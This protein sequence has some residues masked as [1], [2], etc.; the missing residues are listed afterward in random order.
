MK[1]LIPRQKMI[2]RNP[3]LIILSICW[4][5]K[6]NAQ[7][8]IHVLGNSIEIMNNDSTPAINDLTDF[9]Q[10]PL[11]SSPKKHTFIINNLGQS[12]A[13]IFDIRFEGPN[14][15]NFQTLNNWDTSIAPENDMLLEVGFTPIEGG[16]ANTKM[17]IE[18]DDPVNGIFII[19]LTGLG[20]TENGPE[21]MVLGLDNKKIMNQQSTAD[22]LNGTDFGSIPIGSDKKTMSF[23]IINVGNEPLILDGN[24]L[25]EIQGSEA[26]DFNVINIPT[27]SQLNQG[28]LVNFDIEFTPKGIDLRIAQV[29][30]KNSDSNQSDFIFSIAGNGI[31]CTLPILPSSILSSKGDIICKGD[32][33]QLSISP[34]GAINDA[35]DWVWH[36][37]T[38]DGSEISTGE[39]ISVSPTSTTTY[40]VK[41]MG[42]CT[43][44]GDCISLTV[45]VSKPELS[46]EV[47][48]DEVC[49][50][51]NN[52]AVKL[53]VSG[54]IG[55]RFFSIDGISWT[56]QSVFSNVQAGTYTVQVKDQIGCENST[57]INIVPSTPLTLTIDHRNTKC[58]NKKGFAHAK[59]LGGSPPFEYKWTNGSTRDTAYN[60]SSGIYLV[61][62]KDSKGCETFMPVEISDTDGPI[63]RIDTITNV[64]CYKGND[65]QLTASV[66]GG[67]TPYKMLWT[68]G[69]SSLSINNLSV[70]TYQLKVE[71]ANGC[72]GV[73]GAVISE[74][75]KIDL[76]FV[77]TDA[78]C[79]GGTNGTI[80]ATPKGGV[81]PYTFTW[82][83]LATT[84]ASPTN[85]KAGLY[86]CK[87][88][89]SNSCT[90]EKSITVDE[91]GA[92][93]INLINITS[94]DCGIDN[95]SIDI[96]CTG[97]PT[98]NYEYLW[99]SGDTSEDVTNSGAGIKQVT[100]TDAG[101][102][103]TKTFKINGT[104]PDITPSCIV[105]T[106]DSLT[107]HNFIAW[108]KPVTADIVEYRLYREGYSRGNF[109]HLATIAYSEQSDFEDTISDAFLRSWRYQLSAVDICGVES[110]ISQSN[111]T[112]HLV[113]TSD[114]NGNNLLVWDEYDG[115]DF[116]E[117]KLLRY[118][119]TNGLELLATLD[120]TT[121]SYTDLTAPT[122]DEDLN[123]YIE[124][125]PNNGGC[126]AT[127]A[128]DY[129]NSRSN[130][131]NKGRGVINSIYTNKKN[132]FT[133]FPNPNNGEFRIV[134]ISKISTINIYDIQGKA[135]YTKK[136]NS[137]TSASHLISM[138]HV[139]PGIYFV[140]LT[141]LNEKS[142]K[143]IVLK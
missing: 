86:T 67:E 89:D 95:A 58:G 37:G 138:N 92:P 113:L 63:V 4:F 14:S 57:T 3:L 96:E 31:E 125:I 81:E 98:G 55:Q 30:I 76:T 20:I 101:C 131:T 114:Q 22:P 70:G 6:I 33:T 88:T 82:D 66:T 26:L 119:T 24:P 52:N 65:G 71:D 68:T 115:L 143:K 69:E 74:P 11:S 105:V 60:L 99:K 124:V 51:N 21:I 120:L 130:R 117:Y 2:F 90:F 137:T 23:S 36:K 10:V 27:I 83:D 43:L 110:I 135:V 126:T 80:N 93:V 64:S 104:I 8:E 78:D 50:G 136:F 141:S 122:D 32:A 116:P 108:K 17:I 75:N 48:S 123:Y 79:N 53:T 62:V 72:T 112:V 132:D 118:T 44:T 91:I 56:P 7:V 85:L 61:N 77:T 5:I 129:N 73:T 128:K 45:K 142:V 102:S 134:G 84:T 100:V 103:S 107:G 12:V 109:Q 40:F 9:D 87:V 1:H 140:E 97:G 106:V 16:L 38:C 94:S 25:I 127:K 133:L 13:N 49:D 19:E 121:T 35:E 54:I 139:E 46:Y 42:G 18:S 28:Q 41:P 34:D 29:I 15:E 39:S 47:L 59:V 111:K